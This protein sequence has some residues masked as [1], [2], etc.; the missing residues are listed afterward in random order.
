MYIRGNWK[1]RLITKEVVPGKVVRDLNGVPDKSSRPAHLQ[2]LLR[3]S[4]SSVRIE[5]RH[6][7][8]VIEDFTGLLKELRDTYDKYTKSEVEGLFKYLREWYS[9]PDH[10]IS[11]EITPR[12]QQS[13]K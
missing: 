11:I 2:L 7:I 13:G 3:P 9:F 8:F 5:I 6:I 1:R 4:P 10:A 12:S